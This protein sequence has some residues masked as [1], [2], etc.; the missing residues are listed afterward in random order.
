MSNDSD[1][2]CLDCLNAFLNRTLGRSSRI[3]FPF[4]LLEQ[5]RRIYKYIKKNKSLN[6]AIAVMCLA[7]LRAF[8]QQTNTHKHI[9][10]PSLVTKRHMV[11]K[12]STLIESCR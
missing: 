4:G 10:Y 2:H 11:G 5:L 6:K 12:L 3:Y 7:H 9:S 8:I 1:Y